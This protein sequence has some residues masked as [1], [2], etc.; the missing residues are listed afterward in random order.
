MLHPLFEVTSEDIKKLSSEQMEELVAKLAISAV[1]AA[2]YPS[3][4][5]SWGGSHTA[6]DGGVDVAVRLPNSINI[7]VSLPDGGDVPMGIE[8]RLTYFQVKKYDMT[9]GEILN[10]MRP[11]G[12]LRHELARL[13]KD[14]G[15]YVIVSS[16]SSATF[17]QLSNR[18]KAMEGALSD[19]A[20]AGKL[21]LEYFTA[22]RTAEWVRQYPGVA[23]WV[24]D[25][26]GR[27]VEGW[28]SFKQLCDA[29]AAVPG[30][31]I[32]DS[33]AR[34]NIGK[35]AESGLSISEAIG[36]MRTLLAAPRTV[37]RLVGLSGVGKTRIAQALFE[38][39]VGHIPLPQHY[40]IYTDSVCTPDPSPT[41]LVNNLIAQGF[42]AVI[43]IDNCNSELHGQLVPLVRHPASRISLLTIEYDVRE[44]VPEGTTVVT[45]DPASDGFVQDL[46]NRHYPGFDRDAQRAIVTAAGGNARIALAIASAIEQ[47]GHLGKLPDDHLFERIFFQRNGKMDDKLIAVALAASLVFSFTV[48]DTMEDGPT[49]LS[50]IAALADLT[51][52]ETHREL[53]KLEERQLLQ[54]RGHWRALLPHALANNLAERALKQI[55]RWDVVAQLCRADAPHL[56]RSFARRLA[57]FPKNESA[58]IICETWFESGGALSSPIGLDE[59]KLGTFEA[60]AFVA[61][62]AALA[63]FERC[64]N[65]SETLDANYRT[66]T[67]LA[68]C[69]RE[70]GFQAELFLRSTAQL[71][72]LLPTGAGRMQSS[73]AYKALISFFNVNRSNTLAAPEVRLEL[74]GEWLASSNASIHD[75]GLDALRESFGVNGENRNFSD[76][77]NNG[78]D[79]DHFYLAWHRKVIHLVRQQESS[80][81]AN[82]NACRKVLAEA[83]G[84]LRSIPELREEVVAAMLHVAN[85]CFW[86]DGWRSVEAFS[87]LRSEFSVVDDHL[88]GRLAPTRLEDLVIAT[89]NHSNTSLLYGP[90]G[91]ILLQQCDELGRRVADGNL[92][93]LGKI[94]PRIDTSLP[95]AARFGE[96]L[97]TTGALDDAWARIRDAWISCLSKPKHTD[98]LQGFLLGAAKRDRNAVDLWL[99]VAATISG[100]ANIVPELSVY[101]GLDLRG[102]RRIENGLY[103]GLITAENLSCLKRA[104]TLPSEVFQAVAKL[105]VELSDNPAHS[106]NVVQ[107]TS[108]WIGDYSMVYDREAA[109]DL[110]AVCASVISRVQWLHI[111]AYDEYCLGIV[112][113]IGLM[114]STGKDCAYSLARDLRNLTREYAGYGVVRPKFLEILLQ[115]QTGAVLSGLFDEADPDAKQISNSI[116][117]ETMEHIQNPNILFPLGPTLAWCAQAPNDRY[118]IVADFVPISHPNDDDSVVL[119]T[120]TM[121]IMRR[122]P[123]PLEVLT[124]LTDRIWSYNV[125]WS[126]SISASANANALFAFAEMQHDDQFREA[127]KQLQAEV[128]AHISQSAASEQRSQ[129]RWEQKFE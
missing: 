39:D 73:E 42:P 27:A 12:T 112:A 65:V 50:T 127:S 64:P 37:I 106:L 74:L 22:Q 128:N 20:D 90:K 58:R 54:V 6:P 116:V 88:V 16:G 123:N 2:H 85:G 124:R 60:A 34:V 84:K 70:I 76:R 87:K 86:E 17:K 81:A 66:A 8:R 35:E 25:Q 77:W 117:R 56:M 4:C 100:I 1:N 49:S 44:D 38:E 26:V 125:S 122:A 29:T 114:T 94:V 18:E 83:Y 89:I 45:L 120:L 3:T 59:L 119:S 99:D 91:E 61:P 102:V 5:V 82:P 98:V 57:Y 69:L 46:L 72:R 36:Q 13:A 10:E 97:G 52:R 21:K 107:I 75:L 9:P 63:T 110:R 67:R 93:L 41:T 24:L 55:P 92:D 80:N 113:G 118:L 23:L 96:S 78:P 111:N 47:T 126:P 43:I 7:E 30:R 129:S 95:H 103:A 19:C 11:N 68:R 28:K 15:A 31:L 51:D 14:G 71:L 101:A 105:I 104:H 40:A 121:E 33:L 32:P 109:V 79:H 115:V 53:A 108:H 48:V 62:A